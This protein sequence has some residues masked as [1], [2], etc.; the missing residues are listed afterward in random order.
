MNIAVDLKAAT[1]DR[2]V[3]ES[4][5]RPNARRLVEGRAQFVDDVMLPR[6]VHAAFLRSPL[7]HA[8]ILAIRTE[9]AR[10]MPGVLL[11]AT[12][13]DLL[14]VRALGKV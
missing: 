13:R 5:P 7:A 8:K 6:M 9:A 3:G 12:G 1:P 14:H 2:Y 10:A 4:V 11:V